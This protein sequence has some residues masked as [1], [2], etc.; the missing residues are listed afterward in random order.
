MEIKLEQ[1][2]F[3]NDMFMVTIPSGASLVFNIIDEEL[4]EKDHKSILN[5][6]RI[7]IQAITEENGITYYTDCSSVIG[8]G[9]PVIKIVTDYKEL[10]GKV[11]TKDNMHLCRVIVYE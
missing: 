1:E 2:A 3:I 4:S 8:L 5:V 6:N 10:E 7:N 11:L 9:D